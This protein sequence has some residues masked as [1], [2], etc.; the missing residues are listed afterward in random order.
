MEEYKSTRKLYRRV[1][2]GNSNNT[3]PSI[4]TIAGRPAG[5]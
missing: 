3:A 4:G 2:S 1:T 5:A